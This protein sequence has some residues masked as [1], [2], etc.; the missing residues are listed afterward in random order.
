LQ[1]SQEKNKPGIPDSN[2]E[3]GHPCC[4]AEYP[5]PDE[6]EARCFEPLDDEEQ[7][8]NAFPYANKLR[9]RPKQKVTSDRLQAAIDHTKETIRREVERYE[10]IRKRGNAA[11]SKY[12]LGYGYTAQTSG[13]R[14]RLRIFEHWQNKLFPHKIEAKK[15]T[16]GELF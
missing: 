13:L 5:P 14:G 6:I 16:Q 12:D 8:R 11:M 10:D 7:F 15:G 9:L 1:Q 2:Y 4:E 3:L